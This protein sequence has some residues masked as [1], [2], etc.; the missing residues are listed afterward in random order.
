M[1]TDQSVNEKYEVGVSL[2]PGGLCGVTGATGHIGNVLIRRLR[3]QGRRVRAILLPGEETTPIS[4]L[5]VER[6]EA[7]VRDPARLLKALKGVDTLFHLAGVISISPGKANLMDKVNVQ[8]TR[9]VVQAAIESG[10]RR[11]VYTSSV[12]AFVAP[13]EGVST[14]ETTLIDPLRV[15]GAYGRS[16]ARATAEVIAGMHRG[17]DAVIVFPS[18]VIGPYD[19][20]LSE[21]G[22][23]IVDFARRRLFAYIDG[24]YDF[25]DVRDVAEGLIQ[26]AGRGR[27]GEGYLLTGSTV[28]VRELLNTLSELTGNPV[29]KLR[30]PYRLAR[31]ISYLM[32]VYYALN[33]RKPRF[34]T[35]S[36]DV[37]NSNCRMDCSK[38]ASEL[39][40]RRR[41]IRQT[42]ADSLQ[43]FRE[44][45]RF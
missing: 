19:F 18:G 16:K 30:I 8:G 5:E 29:P 34:T 41:P 37:L 13:R 43:W 14:C 45:G 35:Y 38:A 4:G 25:V 12:H 24:A 44:N 1:M 20:R 15:I 7:D 9:N 21:M 40:F 10:V 39:D 3:E 2:G 36:I 23:L 17:L 26:A 27:A 42:L 6:V 31:T 22:Q 28:S 32:P 33:R 11:L